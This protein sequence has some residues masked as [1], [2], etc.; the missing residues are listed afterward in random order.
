MPKVARQASVAT[1]ADLREEEGEGEV[2]DIVLGLECDRIKAQWE[3]SSCQAKHLN[4]SNN[5]FN[6]WKFSIYLS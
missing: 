5:S 6:N 1:I 3:M 4:L 2:Y